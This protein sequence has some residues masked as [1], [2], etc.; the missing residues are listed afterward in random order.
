[1]P[2]MASP[3]GSAV[4]ALVDIVINPNRAAERTQWAFAWVVP[5][6]VYSI[7]GTVLAYFTSG[8]FEVAMQ[9]AVPAGSPNQPT[10]E[11]MG[12]MRTFQT[13][14]IFATPLTLV[15]KWGVTSLVLLAFGAVT[16]LKISAT[17]V[18]TLVAYCGGVALL[19]ELLGYVVLSMSA[20]PQTTLD[21]V[22]KL[23]LNIF[24]QPESPALAALAGYVSLPN[25]LYFAV[26]VE[27]LAAL[28]GVSTA[29]AVAVVG[30][31]VLL[32]LLMSVG[33]V[34]MQSPR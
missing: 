29:R 9:L 2:R 3:V 18:F 31:M 27:G 23:G 13:A 1:M 20:A 15:L 6:V 12:M 4:R 22:P 17:R 5:W 32:Q 24:L 26:L 14:A 34:A 33:S 19:G 16:G 10:A 11:M 30:P 25:I 21:L 7:G 8:I 28:A